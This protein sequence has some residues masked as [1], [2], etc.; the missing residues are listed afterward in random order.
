MNKKLALYGLIGLLATGT[1]VAVAIA[2]NPKMQP[3]DTTAN[4]NTSQKID[5]SPSH[6]MNENNLNSPG[7]GSNI[8]GDDLHGRHSATEQKVS[9]MVESVQAKLTVPEEITPNQSVTLKIDVQDKSGKAIAQFDIFQEKLM[10]LIAVSDDFRVFQHLHPTYKGNGGFEVETNFPQPGN[11]TLFS[12]YKPSGQ[13]EQVSI[14]T[15]KIPGKI[16]DLP[17]RDLNQTK[18]FGDIKINLTLSQPLP[19]IGKEVTLTFNLQQ[20]SNNQSITDLQPYLGEKGHLVIL[21]QSSPLTKVN[22]IHAHAMKDSP[23]GQ[24]QF[25]TTFPQPGR[26]KLWGQFNRNG[27]IVVADFWVNVVW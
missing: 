7:M 8:H 19:K 24:V 2:R 15:T 11:Y 22:Y 4:A 12:D 6:S 21:K 9:G 18:T 5:R 25:M 23:E 14:L 10:H 16:P 17:K 3:F 1:A 20:A 26:Y 27:K 13:T